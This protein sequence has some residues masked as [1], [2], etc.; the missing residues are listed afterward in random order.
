MPYP[1]YH[2]G[3]E[4]D[5]FLLENNYLFPHISQL[6]RLNYKM[7]YIGKGSRAHL[8]HSL[9]QTLSVKV[10]EDLCFLGK[11]LILTETIGAWCYHLSEKNMGLHLASSWFLLSLLS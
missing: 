10:L 7:C 4:K 8:V 2:F 5:D 9:Y 6:E 11:M 3:P 1:L